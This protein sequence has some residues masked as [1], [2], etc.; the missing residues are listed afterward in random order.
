MPIKGIDLRFRVADEISRVLTV[1][2]GGLASYP[3]EHISARLRHL[4]IIPPPRAV[5]ELFPLWQSGSIVS[6]LCNDRIGVHGADYRHVRPTAMSDNVVQEKERCHSDQDSQASQYART[7]IN[8]RN[9]WKRSK[10][11]GG[12]S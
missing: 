12:P 6:E 10:H 11:S 7:V 4:S 5:R 9:W 8:G 1:A 3:S 2:G